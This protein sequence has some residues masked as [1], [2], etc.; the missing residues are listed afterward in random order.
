MYGLGNE[1]INIEVITG[2]E[3]KPAKLLLKDFLENKLTAGVNAWD[4]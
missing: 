1:M 2:V 4:H 3:E